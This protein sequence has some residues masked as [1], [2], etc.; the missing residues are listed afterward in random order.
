MLDFINYLRF[1]LLTGFPESSFS[2]LIIFHCGI[3]V[4]HSEIRPEYRRKVELG[5]GELP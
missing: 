5:I 1:N 4:L 2:L 3:E